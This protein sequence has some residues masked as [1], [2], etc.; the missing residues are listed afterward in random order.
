MIIWNYIENENIRIWYEYL[1]PYN[2]SQ[3]ICIR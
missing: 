1:K 3:I 2:G